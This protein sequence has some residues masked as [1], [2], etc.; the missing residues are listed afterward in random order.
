MI[1]IA[2]RGNVNGEQADRENTLSYVQ[3]ALDLGYHC[4]IDICKWDGEK[5]WLGHDEPTEPVD[6]DWLKNNK[7]WCHAKD[8][9]SLTYIPGMKSS[10]LH[11]PYFLY[12]NSG[13]S[14]LSDLLGVTTSMPTRFAS[15]L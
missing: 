5:F 3:E 13:V 8:Y 6:A 9:N 14:H 12:W 1:L 2:H 11:Q 4:E 10:W 7:L 15:V